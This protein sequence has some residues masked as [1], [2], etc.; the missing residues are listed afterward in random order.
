MTKSTLLRIGF[1]DLPL[2]QI[3]PSLAKGQ[4]QELNIA[5]DPKHPEKLYHLTQY[6]N[7][8]VQ[9]IVAHQALEYLFTYEVPKALQEYFR[10]VEPGGF[11]FITVYD[12]Q[13]V[14]ESLASGKL[15]GMALTDKKG[16]TN[17]MACL[18]GPASQ[19][20][21]AKHLQYRTG[22]IAQR[23]ADKL[24]TAGFT[25]IRVQRDG[26]YLNAAAYKLKPEQK[27]YR[28]ILEFDVNKMMLSRDELDQRPGLPVDY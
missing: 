25:G 2:A 16:Q 15:E 14:G 9:A 18:F 5:A 10:V 24:Q 12:L 13:T 17:P 4:W 1:S 21:S 23:L 3:H 11:L 7:D 19:N 20:T 6:N 26:L 27:P 28:Q 22:F 8:S